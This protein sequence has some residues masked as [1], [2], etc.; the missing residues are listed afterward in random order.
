MT[1]Y[2]NLIFSIILFCRVAYIFIWRFISR[3]FSMSYNEKENLPESYFSIENVTSNSNKLCYFFRHV[4]R[5]NVNYDYSRVL[6]FFSSASYSFNFIIYFFRPR[7]IQRLR[8]VTA[9][10]HSNVN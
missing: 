7:W 6:F 3:G 8:T 10:A 2:N 9:R 1:K 5:R 4:Y